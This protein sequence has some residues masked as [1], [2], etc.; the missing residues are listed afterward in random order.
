[1][2]FSLHIY[3]LWFQQLEVDDEKRSPPVLKKKKKVTT[4]SGR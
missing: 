3:G 2:D 4:L 1:M